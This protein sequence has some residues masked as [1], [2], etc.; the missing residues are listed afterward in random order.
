MLQTGK[1]T[2]VCFYRG[3]V[4]ICWWSVV[5]TLLIPI[6][7][8]E[9]MLRHDCSESCKNFLFHTTLCLSL[10]EKWP[11]CMG[12]NVH[13]DTNSHE[14]YFSGNKVISLKISIKFNLKQSCCDGKCRND[15]AWKYAIFYLCYQIASGRDM[16]LFVKVRCLVTVSLK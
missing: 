15:Q 2:N 6:T 14:W 5:L 4:Y 10:N 12:N 11:D 16:P 3:D 13:R 8:H 9:G 7:A 1:L